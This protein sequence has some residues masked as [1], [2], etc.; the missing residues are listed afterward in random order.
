MPPWDSLD[1]LAGRRRRAAGIAGNSCKRRNKARFA[2]LP[3][4][5]QA[6][7]AVTGYRMAACRRL[8]CWCYTQAQDGSARATSFIFLTANQLVQPCR[9]RARLIFIEAAP[10]AMRMPR[11]TTSLLRWDADAV[12]RWKFCKPVIDCCPRSRSHVSAV[13]GAMTVQFRERSLLVKARHPSLP[14]V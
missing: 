14:C 4:A 2:S 8:Y 1:G 10:A 12:P 5:S 6:V 3:C 7:P 11:G 13:S 9:N